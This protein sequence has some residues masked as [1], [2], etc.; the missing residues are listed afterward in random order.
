MHIHTKGW[1]CQ[2]FF[3]LSWYEIFEFF[4]KPAN[5]YILLKKA[6]YINRERQP[7]DLSSEERQQLGA[8]FTLA[9][10]GLTEEVG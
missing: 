5:R 7:K 1:V 3:L 4:I 6:M 9:Y 10:D 8:I 2:S